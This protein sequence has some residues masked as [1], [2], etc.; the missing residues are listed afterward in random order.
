MNMIL[1]LDSLPGA[2]AARR[3]FWQREESCAGCASI[4]LY[5]DLIILMASTL[6]ALAA[7]R[8]FLKREESCAAEHRKNRIGV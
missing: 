8:L 2:L 6:G 3:F 7:Q 1:T 4:K 5:P